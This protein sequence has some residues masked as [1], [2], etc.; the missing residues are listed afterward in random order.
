M[1]WLD[2]LAS[3]AAKATDEPTPE[4]EGTERAAPG[5]ASLFASLHADGRHSVLDFG[6]AEGRRLRLLGR[7]ARQVRFAAL[8]PHP[9]R[10]SE[11]TAALDDLEP[12]PDRRFDVVLVWDLFDRLDEAER[13]QV[14]ERVIDVTEPAARLYAVV[15]SSDAVSTRPIR[16]ELLDVDTVRE[17]PVG[18][19]E[20]SRPQLLPAHM[21]RLVNPFEVLTGV[22]LR[23]GL[24]EYVA[25]RPY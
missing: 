6:P 24:R 8:V 5:L 21:E 2:R 11:L 17:A 4:D 9:P 13:R 19:P 12:D 16:T 18:P 1:S 23:R 22:S 14:V 15:E 20:P 7:Y 10:G 3:P 25:R